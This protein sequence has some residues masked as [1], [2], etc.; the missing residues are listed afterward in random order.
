MRCEDYPPSSDPV[1]PSYVTT[2]G[3]AVFSPDCTLQAWSPIRVLR[4]WQHQLLLMS[5]TT[6]VFSTDCRQE[7]TGVEKENYLYS[8]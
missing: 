2:A 7:R 6:T 8:V 1:T 4:F 3:Q 5:P